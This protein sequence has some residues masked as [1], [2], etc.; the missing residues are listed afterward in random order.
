MVENLAG[1]L[2][3]NWGLLLIFFSSLKSL[4]YARKIF[5]QEIIKHTLKQDLAHP[6]WTFS[7]LT[8]TEFI[9]F[10]PIFEWQKEKP[11]QKL[12]AG[13]LASKKS[14]SFF[15]CFF[16]SDSAPQAHNHLLSRATAY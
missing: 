12:A 15:V 14:V 4:K 3:L 9:K 13:I 1:H 7:N 5:T 8:G 10:C 16:Q 6:S 2:S 11:F